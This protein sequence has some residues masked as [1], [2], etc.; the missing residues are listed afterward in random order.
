MSFISDIDGA[1]Q[2][3]AGSSQMLINKPTIHVHTAARKSYPG[4]QLAR[5][6]VAMQ[7]TGAPTLYFLHIESQ[8]MEVKASKYVSDITKESPR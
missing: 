3:K 6:E 5:N 4:N 1:N 2:Y 7:A 8:S